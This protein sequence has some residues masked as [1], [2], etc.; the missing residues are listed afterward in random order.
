LLSL[1]ALLTGGAR[2][3]L[4]P[5]LM[6]TRGLDAMVRRHVRIAVLHRALDLDRALDGF[7]HAR[8]FDQ[9]A[10]ASCLN[11]AALALGDLRVNQ[12][13]SMHLE[14]RQGP[15][16][17][18]THQSAIADNVGGDVRP[19]RTGSASKRAV[20]DSMTLTPAG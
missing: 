12:L 6:P 18:G 13:S 19:S 8:E 10:V 5:R 9:E 14:R 15:G 3:L 2:S 16:L 17:V 4:S 11:D 20:P 7:D 1:H